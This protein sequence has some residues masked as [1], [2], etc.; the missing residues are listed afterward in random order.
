MALKN[1]TVQFAGSVV[2][3]WV[4]AEVVQQVHAHL[5]VRKAEKN[6]KIII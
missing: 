5:V 4:V 1:P 6:S 3:H 2:A